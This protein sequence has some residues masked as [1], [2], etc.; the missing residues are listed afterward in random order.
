[1]N[2]CLSLILPQ[3]SILALGVKQK[4]KIHVGYFFDPLF[5]Y[6]NHFGKTFLHVV[7][8]QKSFGIGT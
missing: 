7:P 6:L 8:I 3:G 4:E 1:M 2:E 5:G